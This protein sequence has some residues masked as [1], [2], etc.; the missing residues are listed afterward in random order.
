[1]NTPKIVKTRAELKAAIAAANPGSLGFVPTMG[2]L[3]NGHASLFKAARE[4]N[5]LVVIS[6]FVNE[7]QFN[8]AND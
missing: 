5:E 7:L 6:V 4:E 8:D 1:M 3:H 2:A